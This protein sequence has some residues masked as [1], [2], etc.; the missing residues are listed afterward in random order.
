MKNKKILFIGNFTQQHCSEVHW[1]KTLESIGNTVIR[2]QENG[3]NSKQLGDF[4]DCQDFDIFLFVRTWGETVTLDH[5]KCLKER[6]IPTVSYHLDLYVGLARKYLHRNKTFENV[7]H[8]DP[9]WQCDYVFSPDGDPNSQNIFEENGINHYYM[10]PGVFEPECILNLKQEHKYDVLF[11]G[12]GDKIGSPHIY[13]HPEWNYRNELITWLYKNYNNFTKFG[14]PQETIRNERLNELYSNTKIVI[15][16]SV[17][18][19]FNHTY[20]WSDRIYET[21][22]RGGFLIHPYIKG[23]EEEFTDGEN[24]VFYEYG[25]FEQLKEKIDYYLE[26]SEEREKIRKAGFELVKS[27]CTYTDRMKQML[28]VVDNNENKKIVNDLNEIDNIIKKVENIKIN[29]GSGNDPKNG[30]INVDMLKRNDVDLVHNLMNFPYP[31]ADNSASEI[32]AVDVLE[33]LA[34]YTDD[35]KPTMIA[36]I[37]ECYRILKTGGI[38]YIQV[39][40]WNTEIFEIDITHVRGFNYKSFDFLDKRTWYGSIRDFYT[41]A[42]FEI[43]KKEK[44]ENG[45]MRFWMVKE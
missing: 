15:G 1:A 35:K 45:V 39:P 31:F 11:V 36:F 21:I 8:T 25:N 10:K 4:L 26:H 24:I 30:Y 2:V 7:L 34:H 37:E 19:G 9:F 40:S 41:D 43:T 22:G 3:Y 5:L 20:Y 16:D 23:L 28:E 18:V 17:C 27:K 6:N 42:K 33:H 44:F 29:L 14:H 12:G 13:G 32:M 38:L